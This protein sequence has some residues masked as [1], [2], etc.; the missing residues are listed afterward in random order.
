VSRAALAVAL[1]LVAAAPRIARAG[2][3]EAARWK[4]AA[5]AFPEP[6]AAM[7]FDWAYDFIDT[8]TGQVHSSGRLAAVPGTHE[9]KPVWQTGD[10]MDLRTVR[11]RD[12]HTLSPALATIRGESRTEGPLPRQTTLV[13]A[14]DGLRV[15]VQKHG[16]PAV[17]KA[18]TAP[19]LV[20]DAGTLLALRFLPS[21]PAEYE[22]ATITAD[23]LL[24][25]LRISVRGRQAWSFR[26]TT[27]EALVAEVRE[28][29]NPRWR[30]I[31]LD[32]A[33]R[34]LLALEFVDGADSVALVSKANGAPANVDVS[35]PATTPQAAAVKAV[36]GVQSGDAKLTTDAFH[37][38]SLEAADPKAKETGL[39][40]YRQVVLWRLE[41]RKVGERSRIEHE[42]LRRLDRIETEARAGG[43]AVRIPEVLEGVVLVTREEGGV[44][45]VVEMPP[46]WR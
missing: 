22:A 17:E 34:A 35:K 25:P 27:R 5:A 23:G 13:P 44:W 6:S 30:R 31:A 9:G 10:S 18:V 40:G 21:E 8:R 38:P 37:W 16:K 32:P 2:E 42:V 20:G 24:E 28:G 43:V 4:A 14:K 7:G 29:R 33:T 36:I 3:A 1:V 45:Y 26:G 12:A 11:L 15:R 19:V 39:F 46:A 41:K